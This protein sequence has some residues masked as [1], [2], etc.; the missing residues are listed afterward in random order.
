[1]ANKQGTKD[2]CG[3]GVDP[4]DRQMKRQRKSQREEQ[5]KTEKK[6]KG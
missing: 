5:G 2:K 1:M 6:I 3:Q 4:D